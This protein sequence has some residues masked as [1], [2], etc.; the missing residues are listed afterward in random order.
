MTAP[1]GMESLT[2]F[3]L[4]M[5]VS[6]NFAATAHAYARTDG[7]IGNNPQEMH[8]RNPKVPT[9]KV[10]SGVLFF[11]AREAASGTRYLRLCIEQ[12]GRLQFV[13]LPLKAALP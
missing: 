12:D 7:P 3:A 2:G 4:D 9:G 11:P 1:D 5:V 6:A 8:F 13:K 10:A